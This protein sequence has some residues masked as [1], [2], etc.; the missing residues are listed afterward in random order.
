M[1]GQK[2]GEKGVDASVAL[3][4]WDVFPNNP[5]YRDENHG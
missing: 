5:K 1:C 3:A 2:D 4:A